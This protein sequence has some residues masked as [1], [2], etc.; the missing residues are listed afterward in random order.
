MYL[1]LIPCVYFLFCI[2][3]TIRGKRLKICAEI[4]LLVYIFHPLAILIVRMLGRLTGAENLLIYNSLGHFV[5]TTFVSFAAAC[6]IVR[7]LV[8]LRPE[9][10]EA[11]RRISAEINTENLRHNICMLRTLM[12]DSCKIMA[13]VKAD[14]YGHGAPGNIFRIK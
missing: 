2:L 13:V 6:F 9:R 8:F 7:V 5:A 10:K 14:A 11:C 1:M 12:Q 4:S 3:K